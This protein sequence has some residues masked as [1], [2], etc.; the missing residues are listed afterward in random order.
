M[1]GRVRCYTQGFTLIELLIAVA[2]IAIISAIGVPRFLRGFQVAKDKKVITEM[3]NF[4]IAIGIYSI[5]HGMV[6][7]TSDIT[8]LVAV[9]KGAHGKDLLPVTE[10]DAWG[11]KFLYHRVSQDEYTL[12]SR[13]RDGALGKTANTD[14]FDPNADTVLVSGVFVASHQGTSA[15]VGR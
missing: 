7:D 6:P 2:I 5:D 10:K 8:E 1:R 12:I 4:A 14:Y 15:V 9:L 13:G 11:N 3:R